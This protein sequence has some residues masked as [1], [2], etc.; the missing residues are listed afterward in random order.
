[1]LAYLIHAA[2]V[3]DD[4]LPLLCGT[5]PITLS[6]LIEVNLR[7]ADRLAGF[8][9]YRPI[10]NRLGYEMKNQVFGYSIRTYGNG[11]GELVVLLVRLRKIPALGSAEFIFPR[12]NAAKVKPAIVSRFEGE[13]LAA[14]VGRGDLNHTAHHAPGRYAHRPLCR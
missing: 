5:N 10:E 6:I 2:V 7:S 12:G 8:I 1:M 11:G 4:R 3:G 13:R 9:V 14:M